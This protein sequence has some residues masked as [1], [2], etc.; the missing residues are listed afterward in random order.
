MGYFCEETGEIE[1][2]GNWSAHVVLSEWWSWVELKKKEKRLN[3]V[4]YCIPNLL[5]FS[6]SNICTYICRFKAIVLGDISFVQ[7]KIQ[8]QY[9]SLI[10]IVVV[11]NA[12]AAILTP[13][14][15]SVYILIPSLR[16]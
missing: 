12:E 10:F 16:I 4:Y 2:R 8:M 5:K 3:W 15:S 9:I 13:S 14:P 7:R 6:T 11:N 1:L